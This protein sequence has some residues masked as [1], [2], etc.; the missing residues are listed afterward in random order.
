MNIENIENLTKASVNFQGLSHAAREKACEE[1]K[2][3]EP[4]GLF[5]LRLTLDGQISK[6]CGQFQENIENSNEKISYQLDLSASLIRTHFVINDLIMSGDI[7]E[8]LT[9]IRK[10]IEN[11]TRLVEID[12]KPLGKLLKKTPNVCDILKKSGKKL[13]PQ[14]SEVAH[15]GTPRV[16]EL[17]RKNIKEE[18]KFGPSVF[19]FY[20]DTL[21]EVYKQHSFVSIYFIFWIV[22][23]LKSLYQDKYD[24]SSDEKIIESIFN[25]AV[26]MD[27]IIIESEDNKK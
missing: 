3:N 15:F 7:I 24:S 1:Y 22:G 10:Q 23:F 5:A 26:E 9:L 20:S 17:I 12:E 18:N 13:Y 27:V 8:A 4:K 11:F 25:K 14:L 21:F 2:Q 16:G 19:P 6:L